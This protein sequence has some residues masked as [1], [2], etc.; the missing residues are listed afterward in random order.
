MPPVAGLLAGISVIGVLEAAAVSF[1]GSIVIGGLSQLLGGTDQAPASVQP[2]TITLKQPLV[3]WKVIYGRAR[4]G[5]AWIYIHTTGNPV[6]GQNSALMGVI[7]L[8]CH[9]CDAIEKIYFGDEE[10]KLDATGNALGKYRNYVH[11]WKHL[12]AADQAADQNLINFSDGLWTSAHRLAGRT[13]LAIDLAYNPD[14][15]PSMPV[16]S[17]LVRG[18]RLL[19]FRDGGVRWSDNPI[20]AVEDYLYVTEYGMG[21]PAYDEL[22]LAFNNAEAN[23][24]DETVQTASIGGGVRLP[25]DGFS[26]TPSKS[27]KPNSFV[28]RKVANAFTLVSDNLGLDT[29]DRVILSGNALPP[30]VSAGVTYY[31]IRLLDGLDYI[32][33]AFNLKRTPV[34]QLAASLANAWA[35]VELPLSGNGSGTIWRLDDLWM[36]GPEMKG[37]NTGDQV[38]VYAGPAGLPAPLVHGGQ[39]FWIDHGHQELHSD[40]DGSLYAYGHGMVAATQANAIAGIAITLTSIATDYFAVYRQ[41]EKRYSCNGV[42]DTSAKPS[43]ILAALL[44]SCGG[45]LVRVGNKWRIY[46]AIWRGVTGTLSDY[47]LRGPVKVNALVS[48]RDLFNAVRG[49]YISPGNFDQPSDFPPYPDPARPDLD[50]FLAEDGGERIWSQDIQLP[51]T[52]SPAMAQRLAKILLMQVRKQISVVFPAKLTAFGITVGEVVQLTLPRMGW[53]YKTFEVVDWTF[54]LE[55][56]GDGPPVPGVD[57]T[58]RETDPAVFDWSNGAE[59]TGWWA[60]RTNLPTVRYVPTPAIASLTETRYATQSGGGLQSD[61]TVAWWPV[62]DGFVGKYQI[63][64][65]RGGDNFW[66]GGPIDISSGQGTEAVIGPLAPKTTWCFAVRAVNIFGVASQ[67]SAGVCLNVQGVVGP[68]PNLTNFRVEA[69]AGHAHVTWNK[70]PDQDVL[71]GGHIELRWSSLLTGA[72]WQTATGLRLQLA[73]N[74]T[75]ATIMLKAGTYLGKAIDSAGNQSVA[76]AI[77]VIH[78]VDQPGWQA[79]LVDNESPSFAGAKTHLVV[80]SGNLQLDTLPGATVDGWVDVDAVANWDGE[81]GVYP[82]GE[83][84]FATVTDLGA[85]FGFRIDLDMTAAQIGSSGFGDL[86]AARIEAQIATTRDD[87]ASGGAVWTDWGPYLIGDFVARGIKRRLL[88]TADEPHSSIAC[89]ALKDTI[90]MFQRS[91]VRQ[92]VALSAAGTRVNYD[93]AFFAS[94]AAWGNVVGGV[95]GDYVAVTSPDRSGATFTCR[96]SNGTAFAGSAD[97]YAFGPGAQL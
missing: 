23:H 70:S 49:T 57:I 9:P 84:D 39:Y 75:E 90:S 88:F 46:T 78:A 86:A 29:G 11:I 94:A 32:Y 24:C 22:D 81:G 82:D 51:F 89:S 53:T 50:I 93:P 10:V 77:W 58:L 69:L 16:I 40:I 1:V 55:P 13:Y 41:Y 33:D 3:P 6:I 31:V 26:A 65:W 79:V 96:H 85:I 56:G 72:T 34:I 17:A 42:V 8:A 20:L 12:G 87:P 74:A 62:L 61:V 14:L 38:T 91:W 44:S 71:N 47:D 19:D 97:I 67:W 68:P 36:L 76:A 28:T 30:G 15:F 92:G 4:V 80:S 73:G 59:T 25:Q 83:Y 60:P 35:G 45:K 95:A 52:N 18:K 5:G 66:S 7:V 21:Y 27:Y 54:T 63:V 2:Q 37:L 64:Y 48:R 43:D